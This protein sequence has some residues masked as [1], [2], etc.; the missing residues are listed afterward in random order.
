MRIRQE[1]IE[2]IK[3][4]V[5]KYF[6]DESKTYLFGSRVD[7]SKFGGDIDIYIE[8]DYKDEIFTQ[9]I[10]LLVELKKNIGDRKIDIVINNGKYQLP[11]FEFA[12]NEGILL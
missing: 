10:K 5:I 2:L 6:G 1:Y 8:T 7:D 9:K 3:Q 12:Q 11:I 4:K